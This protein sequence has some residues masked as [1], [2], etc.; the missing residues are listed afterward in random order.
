MKD[1]YQ[2]LI[3]DHGRRPRHHTDMPEPT[4]CM[5]G[6]N[7]LC[8]DQ[9]TV[10]LKVVDGTVQ[11]ASFQG[12]G[13]AISIAA[14]SLMIESCLGKKLEDVESLYQLYHQQLTGSDL[15]EEQTE[16][17][18]KLAAFSGVAQYPMRVKCATLCWHTMDA[19]LKGS[20]DSVSTE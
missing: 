7:P 4:H 12:H 20:S 18:G 15:T 8:G 9:L 6:D 13:C 14:T 2:D 16:H 19:A 11:D 3:L 5:D 17:L 10:Y 1:L